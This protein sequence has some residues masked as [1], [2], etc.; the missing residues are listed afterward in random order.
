MVGTVAIWVRV[1]AEFPRSNGFRIKN[2][3]ETVLYF[4]EFCEIFAWMGNSLRTRTWPTIASWVW[5]LIQIRHSFILI[6]CGS[7]TEHSFRLRGTWYFKDD[8]LLTSL[9]SRSLGSYWRQHGLIVKSKQDSWTEFMLQITPPTTIYWLVAPNCRIQPSGQNQ[10]VGRW[11]APLLE[12][13]HLRIHTSFGGLMCSFA[14]KICKVGK[15]RWM[16]E[17][18]CPKLRRRPSGACRLPS[19]REENLKL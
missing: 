17:I 1:T 16:V 12:I 15:K 3:S 4:S 2:V 19:V 18:D 10:M 6:K 7:L 14:S 8:F 9:P 11:R 13:N 5:K